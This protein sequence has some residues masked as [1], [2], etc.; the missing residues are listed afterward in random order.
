MTNE[1]LMRRYGTQSLF[2]MGENTETE[3]GWP[4]A[5]I[6]KRRAS[7]RSHKLDNRRRKKQ[8]EDHKRLGVQH[9]QKIYKA[10]W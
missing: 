3:V 4:C 9:L 10:G 2:E 5:E 8:K 1:E 6:A 7:K